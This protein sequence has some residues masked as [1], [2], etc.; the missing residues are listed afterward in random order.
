MKVFAHRGASGYAPEN[1]LA[2][3]RKAIDLNVTSIELDVH[4]VGGTLY[5]FH[6]RRLDGKSSGTGLIE[7]VSPEYL[8]TITV[9]GEPIPTLWQVLCYLK[10]Y[11]SVVNI[12]LKGLNSLGPFIDLYPKLLN[13]IGYRS[14]QLLI[15][16]FHHGF[17]ATLKQRLP[18]ARLA[19]LLEGIPDDLAACATRLDAYSIHLS[20]SFITQELI[21]D[22]HARGLMVYVY[23]VDHPQ[24]IQDLAKMGVDGIFSNYPDV[25][26]AI[27]DR[28]THPK[29]S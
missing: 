18:S 21:D 25:S 27:I 11:S 19:P 8:T 24:D 13:E 20:L 1:T 4:N 22:A 29:T 7:H 3:M 26:Q 15:S 6:D 14:E 2:A 23:T 28:L 5:V 16:S 10:A 9:D 17:L 12:E